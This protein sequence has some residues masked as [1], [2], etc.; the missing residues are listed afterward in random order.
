MIDNTP[1]LP[2]RRAEMTERIYQF[3]RRYVQVHTYP[4]SLD[5][6]SQGVFLSRSSVYRHLGK[7]EGSGRIWREDNRAR[8]ITLL[9]DISDDETR[10]LLTGG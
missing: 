1:K 6:I 10:E 5:E 7:L 8:G 2:A 4:P 3:I 9:D